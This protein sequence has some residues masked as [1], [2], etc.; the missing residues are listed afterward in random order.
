[1]QYRYK[2]DK[3]LTYHDR[4]FRKGDVVEFEQFPDELPSNWFDKVWRETKRDNIEVPELAES[5]SERKFSKKRG[6]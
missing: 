2:K 5:V 4:I 6:G 3:K 1:M